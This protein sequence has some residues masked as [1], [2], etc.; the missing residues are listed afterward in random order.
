MLSASPI[1]IAEHLGELESGEL[2]SVG[3]PLLYALSS[4][5]SSCERNQNNLSNFK[6]KEVTLKT[7]AFA[8]QKHRAH[9]N[10]LIDVKNASCE[11]LYLKYPVLI[12]KIPCG[13][14]YFNAEALLK[15]FMWD[16]ASK[17]QRGFEFISP[18]LTPNFS[19]LPDTFG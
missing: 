10:R 2:I 18:P 7:E 1:F 6:R 5:L 16:P 9:T 12:I 17:L 3:R 11:Y 8:P 19:I 15:P 13:F 4:T 14:P